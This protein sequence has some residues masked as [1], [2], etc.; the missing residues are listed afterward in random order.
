MT[1]LLKQYKRLLPWVISGLLIAFLL[2]LGGLDQKQ[3]IAFNHQSQVIQSTQS[4]VTSTA[5]NTGSTNS[6]FGATHL[7]P[8]FYQY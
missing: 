1:S 5:S 3:A 6:D 2:S 8:N 4:T 7:E